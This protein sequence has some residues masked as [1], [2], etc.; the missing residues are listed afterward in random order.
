MS[1]LS[2]VASASCT[3]VRSFPA[4]VVQSRRS[5]PGRMSALQGWLCHAGGG[6]GGGG[7]AGGGGGGG[8]IG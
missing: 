3:E 5:P 2:R 8:G 7:D 1:A 6:E 4:S